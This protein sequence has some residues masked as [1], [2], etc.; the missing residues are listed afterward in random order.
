MNTRKFYI[1]IDGT[2]MIAVEQ[3]LRLYFL[4]VDVSTANDGTIIIH[5][6]TPIHPDSIKL[7]KLAKAL[8]EVSRAGNCP[9]HGKALCSCV[10]GPEAMIKGELLTQSK[11]L[12]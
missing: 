2:G 4:D 5:C 12:K 3:A 10:W 11:E 1:T 9:I 8:T 7:A 6:S